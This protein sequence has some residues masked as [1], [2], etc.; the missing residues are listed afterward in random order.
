[1]VDA[2]DHDGSTAIRRERRRQRAHERWAAERTPPSAPLRVRARSLTDASDVLSHNTWDNVS[3]TAEEE[4]AAEALVTAQ[5][6]AG[7]AAVDECRLRA[8]ARW[9]KHYEENLR[10]YKDRRWLQNEF[11][12]LTQHLENA[13]GAAPFTVLESGC[14]V[15]NTLLPLMK[16]SERICA[17]GCDHAPIAVRLANE[18]LAR[19]GV[20]TARARAFVWDIGRPLPEGELPAGGVDVILAIF[21]LSALPP[22]VIPVALA[23]LRSC[24]KPGGICLFRDYGRLDAKQLKFARSTRGRLGGA[25][26]C[27]WYARGDGTTAFFLTTAALHSLA[28]AAGFEVADVHYDRRLVVNRAEQKRMHRVWVVATLRAPLPSVRVDCS[29]TPLLATPSRPQTTLAFAALAVALAV[30]VAVAVSRGHRMATA[31]A[32]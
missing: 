26:G 10:N 2:S 1:M 28:A 4:A 7:D 3:F 9:D 24:L 13:A 8:A 29:G 20:P 30:G 21:T 11:P 25:H 23:N 6:L 31:A 17:L 32:R 18:R 27:E 16:L 19:E 5:P 12:G 15:G 14:G 22:E